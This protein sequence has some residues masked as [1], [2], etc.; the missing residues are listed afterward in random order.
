M[1]GNRSYENDPRKEERDTMLSIVFQQMLTMFALMFFGFVL[2]KAKVITSEGTRQI[3]TILSLF[4][5]P[6]TMITSFN[7]AFDA[8]RLKLLFWATFAGFLTIFTRIFIARL[9]HKKDDRIDQYATIFPNAGFVGIPLVLATVGYEGVFFMSGYI[10]ANNVTQ[11]TYGQYLISGDKEAMTLRQTL[12]NP[13][14]IGAVIGLAIYVTRL[15]VPDF[16]WNATNSLAGLNTPLA[17]VILGSYIANS[18]LLEVF[19]FPKAYWT[20]LLRLVVTAFVSIFIIYLL[21][22]DNYVVE[23]VLTIASCAP[24]ATNTAILGR[25]FGG[26]YEYGARLVVLTTLLSILT[27]PLIVEFAQTLFG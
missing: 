23:I 1:I 21:P 6:A 24:A 27:I 12:L 7:A 13:G 16:L 3:S 4:V 15:P 11:W 2:V 25:L 20:S 10:M 14:M 17:M 26:D 8:H 19:A 9:L 22:I 18:N 5:M